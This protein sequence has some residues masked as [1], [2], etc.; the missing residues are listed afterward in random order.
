MLNRSV[1][2]LDWCSFK[3]E[4]QLITLTTPMYKTITDLKSEFKRN[5]AEK[6]L[7]QW[8]REENYIPK[9]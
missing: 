6:R 5:E 1:E 9:L 7:E 4:L 8:I 2:D 3:P